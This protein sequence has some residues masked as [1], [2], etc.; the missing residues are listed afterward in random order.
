M[1]S[2]LKIA[3]FFAILI[4]A[5]LIVPNICSAAEINVTS[6]ES[7]FEA[8]NNANT[9]DVINITEDVIL[10]K[11]IEVSGKTITING[12]GNTI[13]A[14]SDMES[15]N[16]S[17]SN[18]SM[19]TSMSNGAEVILNDVNLTASPKYGVQAYNGGKV[20]LNG[21][22]IYGCKYGGVLNNCG[23]VEIVDLTLGH[24]GDANSNN[25]IE[26]SKG[27]SL[28][29]Q[30][31]QPTLVMNGTLTSNQTEN[32]IYIAEDDNDT[33]TSFTVEN[34]AGTTDKLLLDGNKV[35]VTDENNSK[36]FESNSNDRVTAENTTGDKYVPNPVI[37]LEIMGIGP[38]EVEVQVGTVLTKA[39][40]EAVIDLEG[41]N[42]QIDGFYID[43][44]YKTSYDFTTEIQ[45]DTTIYVK[46]AKI[47]SEKPTV[48][49]E[50]D[51]KDDTPKTGVPTYIGTAAVIAAV[52][53][54][55]IVVL[56]KKN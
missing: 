18:K 1:R 34:A 56:K 54:A 39:D 48:P 16:S 3:L 23:I 42:Y 11:A 27:L 15:G 55:S 41:T 40:L 26:M 19:I 6:E 9:G 44:E 10:T 12:N 30:D 20:I 8:I 33:I 51:E 46:L 31:I 50:E 5:L 25:G 13:T 21:V 37:I 14:D 22:N 7:L 35:V 52:S 47:N 36:K 45:G 17:S 43:E 29:G 4:A 49:S 28:A 32:V 53:L 24:N 38:V 2:T